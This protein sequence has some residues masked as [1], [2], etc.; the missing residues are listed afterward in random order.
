GTSGQR[1]TAC[2][3]VIVHEDVKEALEKRLLEAMEQ[4][5]IGDGLDESITVGPI[6]NEA[7]LEKM[8]KYIEI[9]KA[10]GA[11]L[12]AG[13]YE[14]NE[15]NLKNGHFFAPT[16]FADATA[17]MRIAQEEIFGSVVSL[18]PVKSFD[19]AIEVYYS[20]VYY[21]EHLYH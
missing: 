2:S 8:N 10:E 21:Y 1:C 13:G 19:E 17:N 5:T 6:I 9:G 18:I 12:L 11:T 16:L 14:V 20:E 15:G 7:G 3:R 4:L